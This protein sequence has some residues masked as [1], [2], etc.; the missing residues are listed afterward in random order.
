MALRIG[1]RREDKN[2]W[3][4]RTPLTPAAVRKLIAD[5]IEICFQP[6]DIRVHLDEEYRDV[7]AV[8]DEDLSSCPVIMAVKE[9]PASFF[10]RQKTYIFFSHV[11]K[12]QSYNMPMLKRMMELKC[13]LIDYELVTDEKGRRLVFFGRHAGLAGMIDSLWALGRRLEWE[14]ITTPL[15]DVKEAHDYTS[16]ADAREQIAAIGERIGKDG[17]PPGITPLVC[18]FAGYGNVSQGAQEIFNLLPHEEIGPLQLVA[19]EASRKDVRDKL[20]KVVFK[21]EHLVEPVDPSHE[22]ELQDYYNHPEKYRSQ[23]EQYLPH[24]D[25][26]I[27]CI[28]WDERYPRLVTLDYL[29]RSYAAEQQ[30]KLRVIGDISCDID[31][32]IQCTVKATD[33]GNPVY[34]YH[35]DDGTITDGWSGV[36]P[37]V[38]AVDNL[39]CQ[40]PRESS[41]FFS[42]VLTPFVPRLAA[43]DYDVPFDQL[44]LPPE[45]I[46]AVILY[47]G[48]L[49]PDCKYLEQYL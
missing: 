7:G 11:I 48:E 9:I 3:E 35:P 38:M 16:L 24:L 23:F 19:D 20:F 4:A 37:V 6:S 30:R 45:L 27:N 2:E 13:Q 39:P 42:E 46:R 12:G 34:V 1:I 44:D 21:G 29:K 25:M 32:S 17:L 36:G 15:G 22:F 31:G 14:G 33:P 28:Y 43:A 40:L 8:I 49:T 10:E 18:G 41:E 47:Q 5:G 26:L